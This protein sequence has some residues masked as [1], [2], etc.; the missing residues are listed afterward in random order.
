MNAIKE[1]HLTR[2]KEHLRLDQIVQGIGFQ[3][4]VNPR[5]CSIGCTFD[6]YDHSAYETVLG[7]KDGEWLAR[8][9]DTIFEG[10]PA[11]AAPRFA[12]DCFEAIPDAAFGGGLDLAPV[13]WKFLAFLMSENAACVACLLALPEDL[14]EKVLAAIRG[15]IALYEEAIRTGALPASAAWAARAESAAWTAWAASAASAA[16][17]A[18]AESAAW[19]AWAKNDA[20]VRYAA[21]LV[22]LL[23]EAGDA[24]SPRQA[25]A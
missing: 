8:L 20:Y 21:E 13:K 24:G 22:R 25:K 19:P 7:I 2:L 11:K 14:L 10:L 6:N 3:A 12:V 23:R 4:G 17:A 9:N 15:V 5:G 1:T 16:W 18:R